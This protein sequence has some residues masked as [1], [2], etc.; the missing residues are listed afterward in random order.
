VMF[1]LDFRL[2]QA[3]VSGRAEISE[4]ECHLVD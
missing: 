2:A 1:R 3:V 4:G